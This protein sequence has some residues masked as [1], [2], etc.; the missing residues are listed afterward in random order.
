M[1]LICKLLTINIRSKFWVP[2]CVGVLECSIMMVSFYRSFSC[3]CLGWAVS[4]DMCSAASIKVFRSLMHG[5]F[6]GWC[7]WSLNCIRCTYCLWVD[8]KEGMRAEFFTRKNVIMRW[9]VLVAG[10]WISPLTSTAIENYFL[11]SFPKTT[12]PSKLWFILIFINF[13]SFHFIFM[14]FV[15]PSL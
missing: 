2:G 8:K 6:W 14:I 7:I 1:D 3:F 12:K 10:D 9:V 5:S 15:K 11:K 13:V 4:V